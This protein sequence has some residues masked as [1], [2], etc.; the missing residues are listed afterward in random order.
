MW[1]TDNHIVG[2][3][4]DGGISLVNT[5]RQMVNA[6]NGIGMDVIVNFNPNAINKLTLANNRGRARYDSKGTGTPPE[7]ALAHELIH[8]L[9][10]MRGAFNSNSDDTARH[11]YT[12]HA[13][14]ETTAFPM[15][16]EA[17]TVGLGDYAHPRF[18]TT[19]NRIR[20][21]QGLPLRVKYGTPDSAK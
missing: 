4:I 15:R 10:I 3:T 20:K 7:I 21:E 17:A 13:G 6:T 11:T 1:D 16:E 12:N 8:A 9:R 14:I 18:R 2:P 5:F 19:E